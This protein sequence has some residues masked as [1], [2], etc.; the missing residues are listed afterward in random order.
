MIMSSEHDAIIPALP[1]AQLRGRLG[2][3][4]IFVIGRPGFGKTWLVRYLANH[5]AAQGQSV[6]V[7]STDMGQASV[8]VP[9]CLGLSLAAPW[10][11]PAASWFIGDTT[12]IGH[13]LPTVVGAA[14]LAER[15]RRLHVTTLLVDTCGLVDG[16]LG[17]ILTYHTAVA[18]GV[19][20]LVALQQSSE[21][22]PLVALLQGPCRAIH[23]LHPAA[24]A[25]DRSPNERKQYREA[26]LQAYFRGGT[27]VEFD[28]RGLLNLDWSL[29]LGPGRIAPV[30]GSVVGLLDPQGFCLGLGLFRELRTDRLLLFT[31]WRD[32]EAIARVQVGR[33]QLS[34]AGTEIS[35]SRR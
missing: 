2:H 32:R 1:W 11:E 30:P 27:I 9:T 22:E 17:S 4:T 23:R 34:S 20:H 19:D 28:P 12:P 16:Q 21:L 5:L 10:Q 25:H 15:A 24:A 6:G 33:I 26:R 8:G 14:Q 35:W 13:L 7:L 29:G 18:I 3:G 31:T